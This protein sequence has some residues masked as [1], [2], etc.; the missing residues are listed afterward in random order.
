MSHS[1]IKQV[2]QCESLSLPDQK[3]RAPPPSVHCKDRGFN[4]RFDAFHLALA[5]YVY[6]KVKGRHPKI[7]ENATE[8]IG[9]FTRPEILTHEWAEEK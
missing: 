3:F 7:I 5:L 8:S 4:P 6:E 2:F 9:K 1:S